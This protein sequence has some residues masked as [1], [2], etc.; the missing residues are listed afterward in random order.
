MNALMQKL[1]WI[2]ITLEATAQRHGWLWPATLLLVTVTLLIL[3]TAVLPLR[4]DAKTLSREIAQLAKRPAT[5]DATVDPYTA[6]AAVLID[7]AQTSQHLQQ[8][9]GHL[10]AAGIKTQQADYQY[11]TAKHGDFDVMRVSIP[12]VGGYVAIRQGV[13]NILR[14]M[15][16]VSV[17][18]VSFERDTAGSSRVNG[19]I[20]LSLWLRPAKKDVAR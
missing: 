17:D 19:Q 10:Q 14:H 3:A 9:F 18:Q 8:V 2:R 4:S 20:R 5:S 13:A 1:R 12:V 16:G 15:P 7:P 11:Q 6:F